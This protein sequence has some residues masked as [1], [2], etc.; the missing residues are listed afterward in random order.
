MFEKNKDKEIIEIINKYEKKFFN[1]IDD[2]RDESNLNKAFTEITILRMKLDKKDSFFLNFKDNFKRG[3]KI[4]KKNLIKVQ[5]EDILEVSVFK[6]YNSEEIE[7]IKETIKKI[8]PTQKEK[9][10]WVK[11]WEEVFEKFDKATGRKK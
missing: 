4:D 1:Y 8:L 7:L 10:D 5:F 6:K 3:I 9:S 2:E 11:F